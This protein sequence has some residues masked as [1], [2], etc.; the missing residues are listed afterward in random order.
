MNDLAP[1]NSIKRN[2]IIDTHGHSGWETVEIPIDPVEINGDFVGRAAETNEALAQT[3]FIS[4]EQYQDNGVQKIN[5]LYVT[6]NLSTELAS[7]DKDALAAQLVDT[8]VCGLNQ[9]ILHYLLMLLLLQ[10][11]WYRNKHMVYL[12]L[13]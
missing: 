1:F 10:H 7:G 3:K 6:I 11:Q 4:W 13:V 8:S 12:H 9:I 2:D 5:N